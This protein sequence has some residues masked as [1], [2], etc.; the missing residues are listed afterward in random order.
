[1][2]VSDGDSFIFPFLGWLNGSLLGH[3][4]HTN[5]VLEN[6]NGVTL[7]DIL[8]YSPLTIFHTSTR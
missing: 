2:L 5:E 7:T 6:V 3:N 1:M 4:D 8:L